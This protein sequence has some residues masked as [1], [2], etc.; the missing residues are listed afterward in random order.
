[1]EI[2]VIPPVRLR[3]R[4]DAAYSKKLNV[5]AYMWPCA[6]AFVELIRMRGRE[7]SKR[8]RLGGEGF[9]ELG[10]GSGACGLCCAKAGFLGAGD[11]PVVLSDKDKNVSRHCWSACLL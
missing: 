11:G 3:S 8:W 2:D 10:S 6:E 5:G 9:L 1:V 4:V 7:W